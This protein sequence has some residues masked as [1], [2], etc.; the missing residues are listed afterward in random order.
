[1]SK[2]IAMIL[3]LLYPAP[4]RPSPAQMARAEAL[5]DYR[6]CLDD[7]DLTPEDNDGECEEP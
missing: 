1:M 3:A 6:D 5:Q 4:V 7:R 2:S